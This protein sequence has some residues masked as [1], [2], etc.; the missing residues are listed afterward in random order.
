MANP[1]TV[2]PE[3][4]V[5]D[6]V[7]PNPWT[8]VAD[9]TVPAFPR[10]TPRERL[11]VLLAQYARDRKIETF[12]GSA[13]DAR[14]G[15]KPNHVYFYNTHDPETGFLTNLY[16][17]ARFGLGGLTFPT[18]EHSYQYCKFTGRPDIQSLI[19]SAVTG[20]DAFKIGQRYLKSV[21]PDWLSRSLKTMKD[22]VYQKFLQNVPLAVRLMETGDAILVE[23]SLGHDA[24]Y[25]NGKDGRG[26]NHLGLILM[27]LR[28]FLF[29]T[30]GR[31][32]AGW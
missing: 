30:Y 3:D 1:Y 18:S 29:E 11:R 19:M 16:A 28:E 2:V 5:S 9:K 17:P 10:D 21:D 32:P 12:W 27:E 4:D 31:D 15:A 13:T 7:P 20:K 26:S 6:E 24:F 23:D 14:L 8:V 25:G 22:C